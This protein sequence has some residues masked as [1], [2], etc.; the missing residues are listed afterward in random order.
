[1]KIQG[2]RGFELGGRVVLRG[3]SEL[4]RS[5]F[6]TVR[7]RKK[8]VLG[9]GLK[10][11]F[12]PSNSVGDQKDVEREIVINPLTNLDP[13]T[14]SITGMADLRNCVKSWMSRSRPQNECRSQNRRIAEQSRT[15]RKK[16]KDR[17]KVRFDLLRG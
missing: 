3:Q 17:G 10:T 2:N 6:T 4:N 8:P 7:W 15:S 14:M 16:A 1:M 11:M 13:E 9:W 5:H 12:R